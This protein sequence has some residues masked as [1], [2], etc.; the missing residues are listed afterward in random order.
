MT[1]ILLEVC[2]DD[3]DGLLAAI[4]GGADRVELCS[5]LE[6]G[7]LTPTPGLIDLARSLNG[8]VP[9]FAMVRPRA[10][11][12]SYSDREFESMR[13]D[14]ECVAKARLAGIVFGANHCDGTLDRHRLEIMAKMAK[15]FGLG[16]TLHRS[17]DLVPNIG[18]AIALAAEIGIDRILTSGR[19]AKA[20]P[21]GLEDIA[22]TVEIANGKGIKVMAGAGIRAENVGQLF[23]RIP[24]GI[25]E[26]HS[27]CSSVEETN[28]EKSGQTIAKFGFEPNGGKRRTNESEVRRMK[29]ALGR[30]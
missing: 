3:A 11:D 8:S 7:G 21:D 29:E 27:S 25:W 5:A 24:F 1:E 4:R 12:F 19:S 26:V 23:G 9:V 14:I 16:T 13:K 15:E 2:V 28:A 6:V 17:F 20:I 22:K 18:E 10:G 30:D